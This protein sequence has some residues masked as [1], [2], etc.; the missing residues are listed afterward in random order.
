MDLDVWNK[1]FGRA[2]FSKLLKPF[3]IGKKSA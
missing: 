3:G 2:N 1:V